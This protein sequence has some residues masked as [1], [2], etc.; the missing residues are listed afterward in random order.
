MDLT[1]LAA[2]PVGALLGLLGNIGQSWMALKRDR[3]TH[4]MKMAELEVMSKIDLQKADI[5]FRTA[6]E[7]KSGEAFRAAIDA[8]AQLKGSSRL[9]KDILS[10][11]RPGLTA[12]LLITSTILAVIYRETKPELL[13][14]IIV[15]M[16]T[17][18]S[19]AVGY[20]FGHRTDEKMKVT[21]AFPT[22][23]RKT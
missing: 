10:L 18:S 11:F 21:P 9:A 17:M 5:L 8:Q 14:F 22:T 4:A 15:S 2:G 7:E 3:E 19:V 23:I 13:E 12:A 6:V 1:L 16:F 20:W